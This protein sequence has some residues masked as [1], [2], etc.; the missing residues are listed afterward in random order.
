MHIQPTFERPHGKLEDWRTRYPDAARELGAWVRAHPT[1]ARELL[2][3]DRDDSELVEVLTDWALTHRYEG[4][5]DFFIVRHSW[6]RARDAIDRD[7][8][9]K[10]A[11]DAFLAWCRSA[12]AA[13]AEL[14]GHA[15]GLAWAAEHLYGTRAP[16]TART[17]SAP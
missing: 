14:A 1:G 3:W 11:V 10:A 15:H 16:A 12:P 6:P 9:V 4:I 5:D 17:T 8:R 2:G 7:P 13:A